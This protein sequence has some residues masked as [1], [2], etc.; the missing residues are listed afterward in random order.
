MEVVK[1]TKS[2]G[3]AGVRKKA[4]PKPFKLKKD[5]SKLERITFYTRDQEGNPYGIVTMSRKDILDVTYDAIKHAMAVTMTAYAERG[6]T[7]VDMIQKMKVEQNQK[8]PI[9]NSYGEH[10]IFSMEGF[11]HTLMITDE[12]EMAKLWNWL[13][14]DESDHP[15]TLIQKLRSEMVE[16]IEKAK[17]KAE[18]AVRDKEEEELRQKDGGGLVSADGVTPLSSK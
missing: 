15:F 8:I 2:A 11:H 12:E 10:E 9:K 14:N 5:Y 7:S 1:S 17:E 4:E 3:Q 13:G 16:K 18:Q 6:Y